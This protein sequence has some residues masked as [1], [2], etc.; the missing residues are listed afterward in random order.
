MDGRTTSKTLIEV[1][2]ENIN[3]FRVITGSV[4]K[5]FDYFIDSLIKAVAIIFFWNKNNIC[6]YF[7][8]LY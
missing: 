8:S 1:K 3:K 6:I 2:E 4:P 7:S 5:S